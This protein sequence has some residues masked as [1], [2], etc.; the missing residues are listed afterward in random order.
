M[1]S[2]HYKEAAMAK[3][4]KVQKVAPAKKAAKI[5]KAAPVAPKTK[6]LGI[7][8]FCMDLIGQEKTNAQILTAVQKKFPEA[9]TTTK[10]IAWYRTKL[11]KG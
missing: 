7:G 3:A 5:S 4:L 10:S 6:K 8:A 9:N 2:T 11:N 1:K